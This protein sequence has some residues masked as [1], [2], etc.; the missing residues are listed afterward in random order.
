M[1]KFQIEN[2]VSSNTTHLISLDNRR[3]LNILRGLIRGVWILSYDWVVKSVEL[4]KWQ[5]EMDYEMRS[6]SKA[7]EVCSYFIFSS[8]IY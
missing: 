8:K 3:T 2:K 5:H 4:N 1:G 7:V 6:F